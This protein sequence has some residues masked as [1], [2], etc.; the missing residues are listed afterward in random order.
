LDYPP[1]KAPLAILIMAVVSGL[2]LVIFPAKINDGNVQ[3]WVFADAHYRAYK[4]VIPD[5][6]AKHP[7]TQVNLQLVHERAVTSRLRSAFASDLPVPD[8]V[9][10]EIKW[11]GSFFIGP[12]EDIGFVDL[13]EELKKP[14]TDGPPWIERI[15]KSRFAPYTA[16]RVVNGVASD[17]IFGIPHDVHPVLLAYRKDIFDANGIDAEKLA[18]WEDFLREGRALLKKLNADSKGKRH[19]LLE[20]N[21]STPEQFEL[22]LFQN[23]GQIFSPDGAV[24][25]DDET[26]VQ[27]MLWYV[28]LVAGPEPIGYSLGTAMDFELVDNAHKD[29]LLLCTL[30]P[31]WLSGYYQKYVGNA[32]GKMALMPLPAFKPGGRRTST[33]GGT[34][35]GFT[36]KNKQFDVAWE[37]GLKLYFDTD[38]RVKQFK[39]FNILPPVRESWT[40]PEL[41]EANAYW[42]GQPLGKLYAD[43]ADNAPPQYSSPY[44]GLARAK[45]GEALSDCVR[46]YNKNAAAGFEDFVR[47][48][49]KQSAD[50]V[51][52]QEKLNPYK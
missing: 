35:L 29:A 36:K 50:E 26:A 9:E 25:M 10:V 13:T 39:E 48:R 11:A 45:L 51:R 28:P 49:M 8:M 42:S 47:K 17:H 44:V 52:M 34:M 23:D 24:R 18:T 43:Q 38:L 5:F 46:F 40:R 37:L 32:A 12:L 14:R 27:M 30:M 3:L 1:G 2:L 19:Y 7:E 4:T 20:L 33:R 22:L 21:N 16:R 31:D 41:N 15:V 6:E